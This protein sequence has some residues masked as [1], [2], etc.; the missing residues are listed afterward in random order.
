MTTVNS[1]RKLCSPTPH[2]NIPFMDTFQVN[3]SLTKERLGEVSRESTPASPPY[4]RAGHGLMAKLGPDDDDL[5]WLVDS[6][7]FGAFSHAVYEDF[8]EQNSSLREIHTIATIIENTSETHRVG[9]NGMSV[10]V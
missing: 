4:P 6:D 9:V 10:E 3:P 8:D 5:E 2:G 1:S 7:D